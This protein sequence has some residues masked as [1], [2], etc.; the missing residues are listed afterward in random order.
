MKAGF[1]VFV[2]VAHLILKNYAAVCTVGRPSWLCTMYEA[3]ASMSSF[4]SWNL[5]H[6]RFVL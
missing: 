1:C 5:L 6:E 4:P 2:F 3:L